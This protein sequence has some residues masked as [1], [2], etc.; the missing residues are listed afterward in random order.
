MWFVS[1]TQVKLA[2]GGPILYVSFWPH[3]LADRLCFVNYDLCL[4]ASNFTPFDIGCSSLKKD[5]SVK[6]FKIQQTRLGLPWR[7]VTHQK[8]VVIRRGDILV[9]QL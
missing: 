7:S 4:G 2:Q 5:I 9:K 3:T 6:Y 1:V 8:I